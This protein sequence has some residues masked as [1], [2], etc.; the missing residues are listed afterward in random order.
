MTVGDAFAHVSELLRSRARDDAASISASALADTAVRTALATFLGDVTIVG[1]YQRRARVLAILR[2]HITPTGI[3]L[4]RIEKRFAGIQLS[5]GF[6]RSSAP[7]DG[8]A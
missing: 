3:S 1:G 4:R 2:A 6:V 7:A 5:D 8:D